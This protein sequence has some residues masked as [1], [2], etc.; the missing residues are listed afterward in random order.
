MRL[1]TRIALAVGV[2]VPLLVLASGWLL[3]HLVGDDL[4]A[5]QNSQLR[6][7]ATVVAKNA[8]SFLDVAGT[9]RPVMKQARKRRL[10]NSAR[11]VG[12]RL[13][14]PGDTISA[15][16][17]PDPFPSLPRDAQKPVTVTSGDTDWLVLS[18]RVGAAK[19]GTTPNLWLF[20]PDTAEEELAL[21]R[22]RVLLGALVAAPWPGPPPGPSRPGRSCRC[23][24]CS[25]APAAWT[26]GPAPCAWS[27]RRPVSAR[28]TT[29]RTRCRPCSPAT[30]S[31]SNAP[32]R[33]W[34]PPARS[35]R[36]RPTSCAPR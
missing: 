10:V 19:G 7:R 25:G 14:A 23:G 24:G 11:D 29:S 17:Q 26:P 9:D 13:T 33:R 5:H 32:G 22:Q 3:L 12:I 28:S 21:V 8:K 16:P 1:S 18:L 31:R 30:T 36:P 2:S 6:A 4:R 27:T 20:S 35:P 15:G 34:P